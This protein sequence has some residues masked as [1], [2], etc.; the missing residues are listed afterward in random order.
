MRRARR[1]VTITELLTVVAVLTILTSF[2]SPFVVQVK[3]AAL[4]RVCTGNLRQ[5]YV[6]IE[7]VKNANF[8]KLPACVDL[9]GTPPTP[10]LDTT[11]PKNPKLVDCSVNEN[12]WWF[13]K[14]SKKLYPTNDPLDRTLPPGQTK[15]PPD[16]PPHHV[17]LRC[18]ASL[19]P[20]DQTRV[21]AQRQ[22]YKWYEQVSGNNSAKDHVFDDVYGYNNSGFKYASVSGSTN[23]DRE[24]VVAIPDPATLKW[25]QVGNS[26]YY[27]ASGGW[28]TLAG[29]PKHVKNTTGSPPTCNCG[30]PWPCRYSYLGEFAQVPEA[31]QTMLI[32]DYVKADVAPNMVNDALR[33]YRFRH[34]GVAN[35]LFVDGHVRVYPK[36]DFMKD[37]SEP[38]QV[39]WG[40]ANAPDKVTQHGRIHWAVLRP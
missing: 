2:V 16:L 3:H 27:R 5:V 1:G 35:I 26:Y 13:L 12:S 14:V 36:P 10:W 28:G 19:D 7:L 33:G 20:Y 38:D 6:G 30:R 29:R 22:G 4:G 18:P 8:S 40:T 21:Y 11:D 17:A 25:S 34:G 31:A 23:T 15:L 9:S 24:K 37:W 39:S 32:A